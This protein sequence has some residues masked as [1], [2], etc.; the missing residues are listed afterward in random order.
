M[1]SSKRCLLREALRP[2]AVFTLSGLTWHERLIEREKE[3]VIEK[4]A[5]H[6]QAVSSAR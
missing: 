1:P 3:R 5:V 2:V 6:V 4:D